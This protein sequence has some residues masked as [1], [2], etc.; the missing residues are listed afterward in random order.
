MV[1]APR[2]PIWGAGRMH[3]GMLSG[4]WDTDRQR[5]SHAMELIQQLYGIE[6]Y[7]RQESMTP[8]ERRD[9]RQKQS[10]P[11]L[12]ELGEWISRV[13]PQ[14]EPKSALGKAMYYAAAHWEKN[15]MCTCRMEAWRL[16][17]IW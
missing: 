13:G 16:I 2:L 8:A 10:I 11:I 4:R 1:S 14:T 17:T 5:A 12:D 9:L 6:R 3:A 7:A 15:S